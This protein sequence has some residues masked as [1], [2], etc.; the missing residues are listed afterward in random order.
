M[1]NV[2][3]L[4]SSPR[5]GGNT[6]LLC[7]AF[8]KGAKEA[9]NK[10]TKIRL[11]DKEIGFCKA[12]S[13]CQ[14]NGECVL[15]DDVP[16]ILKKLMAADVIVFGTPVYFFSCS[17]QL[18]AL[19]DRSVSVYPNLTNKSYYYL[20]A[21]AEEDKDLFAGTIKCLDGFLDCYEGSKRKGLV[22]APGF[23]EKGAIKGSRFVEQAYGL[24]LRVK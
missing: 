14:K 4:S 18:K 2:V 8:A 7:D 10:V 17:A 16:A 9:G 12:C 20:M 1:K 19:F 11:A 24:G 6:D 5:K 21:M 3:I 23:Y 15:K 13:A 22:C